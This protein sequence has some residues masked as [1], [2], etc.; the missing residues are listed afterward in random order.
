MIGSEEFM[1]VLRE[2]GGGSF[3]AERW[4]MENKIDEDTLHLHASHYP[5]P[6][7]WLSGFGMGFELAKRH[8]TRARQ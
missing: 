4:T 5:C 6:I 7:D 2:H 3:N 1:E 8:L